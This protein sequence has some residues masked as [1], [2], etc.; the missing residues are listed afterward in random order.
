MKTKN[1][2]LTG[3][4][5]LTLSAYGQNAYIGLK[6]GANFTNVSANYFNDKVFKTGLSIGLTFDYFLSN[7]ISLSADLMYSQRGF[8][9]Y[10]LFGDAI[11]GINSTSGGS[12]VVYFHYDY[13]SVPLKIGYS[14]GY[15]FSGFGN[16]GL[17]PSYLV[18]AKTSFQDGSSIDITE[19]GKFD[20][21]GQIELGC[22]YKVKES[23]FIYSSIS[24][25]HSFTYLSNQNYFSRGDIS[26]YGISVS[27]GLKYK[28][29]Q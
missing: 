25:F 23:Y 20:L 3:I 8:G 26:N 7:K 24:Y 18:D 19:A 13:L 17:I 1:A 15:N 29:T 16:V 27:F 14:I 9:N 2:F 4:C 6:T 28:L 22:G 12:E 10:Y 5:L 21:A 11:R